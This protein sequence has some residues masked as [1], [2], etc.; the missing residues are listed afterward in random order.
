MSARTTG[1]IVAAAIAALIVGAILSRVVEPGV[2][3]EKVMLAT[4]TKGY[5]ICA[6]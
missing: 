4:N 6:E 3:V 5:F 2:R 1:W